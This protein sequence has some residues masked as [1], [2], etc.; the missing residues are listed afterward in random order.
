MCVLTAIAVTS[1]TIAIGCGSSDDGASASGG[2]THGKRVTFIAGD[3][4]DEFYITLDCG[5]RQEA[6]KYGMSVN[7]QEPEQFAPS[8]Q[9]PIVNA[10]AAKHPDALLIAPTDSK[11]M[12]LPIKQVADDGTKVVLVDTTLDN[13]T[14]AVSQVSTND[15]IGGAQAAQAL[16]KLVGGKGKVIVINLTPGVST[17]DARAK[18]FIDEAKKLGLDVLPQQY[19]GTSPEKAASIV[20]S[21]VARNPDLKGIFTTTNFAQEGA[22][23]G[24]RAQDL[25]GKVKIV[26]FDSAPLQVKQLRAGDV[27]ALIAQQ[28]R[29]IGKLG[30]DQAAATLAGKPTKSQIKVPTVTITRDNVD[31]PKVQPALQVESC[32]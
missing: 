12:Y 11:A 21:T 22:V 8:S 26:G 31:D 1:S 27:Q 30:I 9:T 18:G 17:T 14:M 25:L 4:G 29:Q 10:T 20:Q 15:A 28:A 19:A 5:A 3:K 6:Q 23:T 13:P 24:L 7:F 16:A 2:G 32:S